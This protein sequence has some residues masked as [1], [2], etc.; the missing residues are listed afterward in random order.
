MTQNSRPRWQLMQSGSARLSTSFQQLAGA[1]HIKT[2]Q[3]KNFT[4]YEKVL[5]VIYGS[6]INEGTGQFR[7]PTWGENYYQYRMSLEGWNYDS[8]KSK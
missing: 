5:I 4:D 1:L 8:Q 3:G 7:P 2:N 6:N